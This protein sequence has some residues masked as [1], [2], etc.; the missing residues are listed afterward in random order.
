MKKT[1]LLIAICMAS[2]LGC[3]DLTI[4][5]TALPAIQQSMNTNINVLQWVMTGLLAALSSTMVLSGRLGD[6]FG[7]RRLML[8]GLILFG[9]ASLLAGIAPNIYVLIIARVLQ[10]FGI[11]ILYTT[12]PAIINHLYDKQKVAK[13]MG[14]YFSASSLGIAS[15]PLVG[16]FIVG[17]LSWQW[18]FY[19]N[20]PI[21]LIT[22]LIC[23]TLLPKDKVLKT[24][25][26]DILGALLLSASLL[27]LLIATTQLGSAHLILSLTF[28]VIAILGF[29]FFIKHEKRFKAPLLN[30]NLFHHSAFTLGGI[31]NVALACFYAVAF[32]L[33]PLYLHT[34]LKANAIH[35]GLLLLPTTL[36]MVVVSP[37]VNRL[38]EKF[39][40]WK[41]LAAGFACLTVNAFLQSLLNEQTSLITLVG[42]YA[43]FGCGWALIL[44]PSFSSALTTIPREQSGAATGTLGTL[45]NAGASIGLAFCALLFSDKSQQ[46]TAKAFIHHQKTPFLFITTVTGIVCLV[47][48]R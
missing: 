1:L 45:H 34:V 35:I 43:L 20:I 27:T 28:F 10:G 5:N 25:K 18:I 17:A 41:V 2:F 22:L 37:W 47:L 23:G 15:G 4:V 12:P 38:V 19:L 46:L 8:V 16:G 3:L 33:M 42:V 11:A 44:S 29:I 26:L 39:S 24:E 7:H 21:V 14:Y 48:I 32:F 9:G 40:V 30:L 36:T 31:A 13:A 6:L